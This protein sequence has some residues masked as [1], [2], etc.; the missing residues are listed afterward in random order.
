MSDQAAE[1][2]GGAW[3]LIVEDDRFNIRL[4]SEACRAAGLQVRVAMDG[5]EG[6]DEALRAPPDLMLLDLMLPR[7]DGFGVLER[8][9]ADA[10]T[11]DVAVILVTAVTDAATRARGIE[12]GADDFVTKP[13]RL[14]DLRVRMQALLDQRA[15]ERSLLG[16]P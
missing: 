4:L 11:E 13:F 5:Q 14:P 9:R 1:E 16:D 6:L 7:L 10:R 8:L 3:V 12:L 15:L 2:R